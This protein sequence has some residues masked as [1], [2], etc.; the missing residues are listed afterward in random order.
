MPEVSFYAPWTMQM[1]LPEQFQALA[2]QSDGRKISFKAEDCSAYNTRP[3]G[4]SSKLH[5]PTL[6][7][8]LTLVQIREGLCAGAAGV[9]RGKEINY[10]CMEYPKGRERRVLVYNWKN[11]RFGGI[12]VR[13][14]QSEKMMSVQNGRSSGEE[15]LAVLAYASILPDSPLYDQ[16]FHTNFGLLADQYTNGWPAPLLALRAAFLCCDNLYQRLT[17]GP[18]EAIPLERTQFSGEFLAD[19][20]PEF[21][22]AAG[23][24]D[25]NS[26]IAGK[27]EVL[28]AGRERKQSTLAELKQFYPR[29]WNVNEKS[30]GRIPV[31]PE[32]YVVSGEAEDVVRMVLNTPARLFMMTGEAGTGKTTDARMIAQILGLPYYVFT[33][34][35]GTDELELLASTVPNMGKHEDAEMELPSLEDI[36]MDPASALAVVSGRYQDGVAS[37]EAF[38]EILQL[39]FRKGYDAARAEKDFVLKESEIV[40][41]CRE[42]SVLEIQEPAMIEKPG[43][44]TRLN[45]LF[46]DGAV[47]DLLNGEMIRRNPDTIVIMT[48]NLD[49]VGCQSF[50]QSVLSRMS[51]IQ[52]KPD[53]SEQEMLQRVKLRT[54]FADEATLQFMV[55]AIQKIHAYLQQEDIR[56][57]VCG[58]RE[59]ENW[60]LGYMATRNLLRS[61]KTAVLSK[62]TM[63]KEEQESLAEI[64][65]Q[66]YLAA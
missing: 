30:R 51:L 20:L 23:V 32:D 21:K 12:R 24:F 63:D 16:E 60:V 38:R 48:T 5:P 18:D 8:I 53:L 36:E 33:C 64:F 40:K 39:V 62:A 52:P 9:Q 1:A 45:S 15:Y 56:G 3:Q 43:T 31:L 22:I 29:R 58:Y 27:F 4:R 25:P 10:F 46:D 11:G 7:A 50:N 61:A 44:L 55:S 47:T 66:P 42:P 49:Y 65:L 57:G 26:Q 35:P 37:E 34:G 17:A 19:T 54:G 59:L 14:G 13:K 41:A 6:S 28:T 2:D